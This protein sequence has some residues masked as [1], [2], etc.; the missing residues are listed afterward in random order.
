MKT[1][2]LIYFVALFLFS[3]C[4]R[5]TTPPSARI[6]VSSTST[7]TPGKNGGYSTTYYV[8]KDGGDRLRLNGRNLINMVSDNEKALAAAKT[9]KITKTIA[10]T[11]FVT[12]FAGLTYGILGKEGSSTTTAKQ[13]G[14]ISIP[15]LL[16]C[17][18]LSSNR[19]KK[20][21]KIY[22]GF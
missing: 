6:Q 7:Y 8:K 1:N 3:S 22:N 5:F 11:S 19:A 21:I 2:L 10:L 16:V 13:I 12:M 17:A 18:P 15:V 14:L 20:A 4:S 9:Y